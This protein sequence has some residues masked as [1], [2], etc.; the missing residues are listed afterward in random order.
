VPSEHSTLAQ[1]TSTVSDVVGSC[2]S[3]RDCERQVPATLL[4][5]NQSRSIVPSWPGPAKLRFRF[6]AG[7]LP[8]VG[9]PWQQ[10]RVRRE[11]RLVAER[12]RSTSNARR[13]QRRHR[14]R[15]GSAREGPLPS[16]RDHSSRRIGCA[17]DP[18]GAV[19]TADPGV[20][21]AVVSRPSTCA[22]RAQDAAMREPASATR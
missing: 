6:V 12:E 5:F 4:T 20:G 10:F 16:Y 8:F 11:G 14:E 13:P 18:E 22:R 17:I 7:N 2:Q 1:P 9:A 21:N 19:A 3:T 15:W